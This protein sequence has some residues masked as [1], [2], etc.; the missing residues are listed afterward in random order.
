MLRHAP[1][2]HSVQPCIY[3]PAPALRCQAADYVWLLLL[4]CFAK[5]PAILYDITS[6]Q[7]NDTCRALGHRTLPLN[8]IRHHSSGGLPSRREI[9]ACRMPSEPSILHS[10]RMALPSRRAIM[11]RRMPSEPPHFSLMTTSIG[12]NPSESRK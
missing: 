7:S 1:P 10:L 5:Q 3:V 11:S 9:M 8:M 12:V 4:P 2:L 6:A